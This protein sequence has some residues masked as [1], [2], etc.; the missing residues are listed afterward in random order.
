MAVPRGVQRI[1]CQRIMAEPAAMATMETV[2]HM[3]VKSRFCQAF[4]GSFSAAWLGFLKEF[5][6]AAPTRQPVPNP[7][8]AI[9]NRLGLRDVNRDRV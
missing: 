7:M 6:I 8:T 5:P 3:A 1:D 9:L 4:C 2:W